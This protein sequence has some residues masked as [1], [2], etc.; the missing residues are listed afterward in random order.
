MSWVFNLILTYKEHKKEQLQKA[1]D[2]E[3]AKRQEEARKKSKENKL[4]YHWMDSQG[5]P[6]GMMKKAHRKPGDRNPPAESQRN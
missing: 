2:S 3:L 6:I 5:G 4:F 1:V